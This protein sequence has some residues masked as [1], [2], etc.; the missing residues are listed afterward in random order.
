MG[1][2]LSNRDTSPGILVDRLEKFQEL[3]SRKTV[4]VINKLS[5][6]LQ[7]NRGFEEFEQFVVLSKESVILKKALK[8]VLVENRK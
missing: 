4:I 1:L 3:E 8:I 5:Q 6:N 7:P 2:S